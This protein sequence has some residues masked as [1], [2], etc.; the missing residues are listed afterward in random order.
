MIKKKPQNIFL[1]VS[2]RSYKTKIVEANR[3]NTQNV[4]DKAYRIYKDLL[5]QNK[6]NSDALFGIASILEKQ[7]KFDLA[8]Q[9][10][11]KAIEANPDN[12]EALLMRGRAFRLQGSH[13]M[14]FQISQK[15]LNRAQK[16]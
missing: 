7:Q 1:S 12:I 8:I 2:C 15:S 9:F 10:L 16:F 11:T 6:G 3:L 4:L 5:G 14:Q 13:G